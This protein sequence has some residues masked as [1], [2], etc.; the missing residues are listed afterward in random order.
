MT[1]APRHTLFCLPVDGFDKRSLLNNISSR[2]DGQQKSIVANLNL[3]AVYCLLK[4]PT[5]LQLFERSETIVHIDGM[6]IVALLRLKGAN[7]TRENRLTY[8]DWAPDA[9]SLAATKGWRVAYLGSTSEICRLGIEYFQSL[10]PRLNIRGWDGFFDINDTREGSKLSITISE[11]NSFWPDLLIVGMGMPRQEIFI[12]RYY[13]Q[14]NFNVALCSGAFWE[15]FVGGQAL[16][17]RWVGR[18]GLEWLYRL[19][20]NPTRYASR[21]LIEPWLIAY[22]L[23]RRRMLKSR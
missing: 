10:H 20:A 14:L 12:Q 18:V 11:I 13:D 7:V 17:P 1:D 2:I 8:L 3:H 21:Y 16:P 9:I 22:L 5:M 4:N 6:P 19:A 15:Y 23:I